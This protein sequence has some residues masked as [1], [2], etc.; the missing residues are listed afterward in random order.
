[1]LSKPGA[2][3]AIVFMPGKCVCFLSNTIAVL[4]VGDKLSKS[5]P[6]QCFYFSSL[7]VLLLHSYS[8]VT[9]KKKKQNWLFQGAVQICLLS[10]LFSWEQQESIVI[11]AL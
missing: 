8:V 3:I 1:M 10:Y 6:S 5:A 7:S 4:E 9:G 2:G 11:F